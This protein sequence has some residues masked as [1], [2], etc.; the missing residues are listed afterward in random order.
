MNIKILSFNE[1]KLIN[2]MI[3]FIKNT[4]YCY[5][6][7]LFKLLN[8]LDFEHYRQ[9]GR[10]VTG[11]EYKALDMGPVPIDL[12]ER[13]KQ[14]DSKITDK[15]NIKENTSDIDKVDSREFIIKNK[16][17]FNDE[18]FSKREMEILETLS[19]IFKN[20]PSE[21]ISNFSH[22]KNSPWER[23]YKKGEGKN[24]SIPYEL[25]LDNIIIKTMP[26]IESEELKYRNEL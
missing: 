14:K 3:Y 7:K 13:I 26:T 6:I 5:T 20:T 4:K 25:A 8:F 9:T 11:L 22:I 21:D 2:A 1:E 16:V 15:I 10:G 24:Q 19:Y 18:Y 17:K 23:I 12:H